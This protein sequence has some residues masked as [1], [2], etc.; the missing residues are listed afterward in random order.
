MSNATPNFTVTAAARA[1]P[2]ADRW[3]RFQAQ[4]SRAIPTE[5]SPW[6]R[7]PSPGWRVPPARASALAHEGARRDQ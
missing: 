4:L 6:T 3:R 5:C 7:R 1:M 2:V